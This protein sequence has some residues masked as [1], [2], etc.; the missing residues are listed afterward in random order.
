MVGHVKSLQRL[1][2]KQLYLQFMCDIEG[3]ET[4]C[5]APDR[6]FFLYV[7]EMGTKQQQKQHSV[8]F[9]TT[10]GIIKMKTMSFKS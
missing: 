3:Q 4:A 8:V 7:A 5:L 1:N 6:E 2:N 10:I 9:F